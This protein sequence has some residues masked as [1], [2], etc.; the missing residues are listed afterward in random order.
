[1]SNV[2]PFPHE[3]RPLLEAEIDRLHS[4]AFRNLEGGISDCVVMA[5][6]ALELAERAIKGRQNKHEKAMFAVFEVARMLKRLKADY[7]AAWHDEPI[8]DRD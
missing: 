5:S 4:A 1:M 6:I 7:H 2:V 8:Y 3:Q